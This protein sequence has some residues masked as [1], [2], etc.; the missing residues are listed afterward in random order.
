MPQ[1]S[2]LTFRPA[3][4]LAKT[5]TVFLW[6][7]VAGTVWTAGAAWYRLLIQDQAHGSGDALTVNDWIQSAVGLAVLVLFIVWLWWVRSNAEFLCRAVHRRGRGWVVG[8]WFVPVINLWWPKQ[9]VDDVVAASDPRTRPF[10]PNLKEVRPTRTVLWWW[11]SWLA[12]NL[13]QIAAISVEPY[14]D[15]PDF[16]AALATTILLTVAAALTAV[17]AWLAVRV[18][19]RIGHDQTSR[20]P[21]AW[22]ASDQ[23]LAGGR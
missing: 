3:A 8:A 15:A 12:A 19:E 7:S 6:L 16:G 9:I 2:D 18:I 20:P 5:L 23:Y 13:L 14:P 1:R 21:V 17:A 10:T 22:W 4:G 11:L